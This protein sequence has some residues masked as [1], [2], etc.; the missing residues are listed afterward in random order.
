[1]SIVCI[2]LSLE[3]LFFKLCKVSYPLCVSSA[4]ELLFEES[5]NHTERHTL[6]Y[7]SGTESKNIGIIM[8]TAH[9]CH[10]LIAAES[11]SDS[12]VLIANE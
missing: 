4:E 11:T 10:E 7:D 1:M 5:I 3:V 12:L 8:M 9:L 6:T 2:S